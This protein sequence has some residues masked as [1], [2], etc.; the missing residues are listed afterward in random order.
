MASKKGSASAD[1]VFEG[2]GIQFGVVTRSGQRTGIKDKHQRLLKKLADLLGTDKFDSVRVTPASADNLSPIAEGHRV[3]GR[4]RKTAVIIA[5][6]ETGRYAVAGTGEWD[7]YL[8]GSAGLPD[9]PARQLTKD[10]VAIE[11]VAKALGLNETE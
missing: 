10:A 4:V 5:S 8:R 3:E 1:N 7:E 11:I 9:T 2:L 6:P